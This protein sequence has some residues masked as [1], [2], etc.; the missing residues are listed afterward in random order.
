VP[1]REIARQLAAAFPE[2]LDEVSAAALTGAFV[3]AVSGALQVLLEHAE[4]PADPAA[5]RAATDRALAP[6]LR[7]S[8]PRIAA[9]TAR[10]GSAEP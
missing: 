5:V 2:Q 3:G 6:W 1:G 10:S 8:A 9:D 7:E 4:R